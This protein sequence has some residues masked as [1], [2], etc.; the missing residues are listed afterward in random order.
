MGMSDQFKDKAK[1]LADQAKSKTGDKDKDRSG[2]KDQP[3]VSERSSQAQQR[4]RDGRQT[5]EHQAQGA[6]DKFDDN[7]DA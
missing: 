2:M 6:R 5:G 7:F 4:M 3:G 1:K